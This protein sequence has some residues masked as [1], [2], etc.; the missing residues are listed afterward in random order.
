MLDTLHKVIKYA[1]SFLISDGLN[2]FVSTF[3]SLLNI[4][5]VIF[6]V[7]IIVW[8]WK[9]ISKLSLGAIT[10]E[11]ITSRAKKVGEE[12]DNIK[13]QSLE[14]Q[15]SNEELFAFLQTASAA[16][17]G[18][19]RSFDLL[20]AWA[21]NGEYPYHV[22]AKKA[23]WDIVYRHNHDLITARSWPPIN[24][25]LT[26]SFG[27]L[28]TAIAEYDKTDDNLRPKFIGLVYSSKILSKY[29]K[30][31]F[32]IYVLKAPDG[33]LDSVEVAGKYF[34]LLAK[35]DVPRLDIDAMNQWWEENKASVEVQ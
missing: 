26:V 34:G 7:L 29:E 32:M 10:I 4:A 8:N 20:R 6:I 5:I 3:S 18:D 22:Q 23:Y 16:N 21:H 19:K 30:M 24:D 17:Y 12:I 2:K 11:K 1:W 15:K 27:S 25:K 28:A 9:D 35:L 13:K 31:E 14:V 33:N